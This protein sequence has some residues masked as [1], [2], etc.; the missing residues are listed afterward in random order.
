MDKVVSHLPLSAEKN[1]FVT[2]MML[3]FQERAL[4]CTAGNNF[5]A[6][7]QLHIL[8][9]HLLRRKRTTMILKRFLSDP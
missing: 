8:I 1:V 9:C 4:H 5:T 3:G 2:G 7:F 6:V